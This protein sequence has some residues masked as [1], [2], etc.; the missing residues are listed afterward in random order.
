MAG[1]KET[2]QRTFNQIFT[3]TRVGIALGAC[4]TILVPECAAEEAG[5]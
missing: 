2:A 5:H 1:K 3:N 4:L